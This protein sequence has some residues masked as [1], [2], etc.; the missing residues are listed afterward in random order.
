V[1]ALRNQPPRG[2]QGMVGART[3]GAW[4][5]AQRAEILTPGKASAGIARSG[6]EPK[7]QAGQRHIART[8]AQVKSIYPFLFENG[9]TFG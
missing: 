5:A 3:G 8:G 6:Q 9:A 7:A 4:A 2:D 1:A